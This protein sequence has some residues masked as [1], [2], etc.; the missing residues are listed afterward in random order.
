[1][2]IKESQ[3]RLM[4]KNIDLKILAT[5]VVCKTIENIAINNV[6][7]MFFINY[8]TNKSP[9]HPPFSKWEV[10]IPPF[11]KGGLGGF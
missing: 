3:L 9:S 11:F 10:H 2:V 6:I 5:I 8:A 4:V 1:M 7:K